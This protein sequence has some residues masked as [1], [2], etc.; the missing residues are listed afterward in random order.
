M[1][2]CVGPELANFGV[3]A[4]LGDPELKVF[5]SAATEISANDN[6]SSNANAATIVQASSDLGAF[7]LTAGSNDAAVLIELSP[8]AY[9]VHARGNDGTVGT[10][11]LEVY[12]LTN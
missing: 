7:P 6:W 2:R 3:T 9:T 10:V 5:N 11:L 4:A 8:G 1:I 12:F